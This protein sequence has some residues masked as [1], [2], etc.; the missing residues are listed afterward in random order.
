MSNSLLQIISDCIGCSFKFI[1]E[2]GVEIDC[3]RPTDY[4]S[5]ISRLNLTSLFGLFVFLLCRRASGP[6]TIDSL[7][8][9]LRIKL[10]EHPI[11]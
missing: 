7:T 8:S 10:N 1:L 6:F 3:E 5:R 4:R 11:L 2:V 9:T